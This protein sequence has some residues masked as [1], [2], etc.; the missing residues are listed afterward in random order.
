MSEGTEDLPPASR[1][2]PTQ[3][4]PRRRYAVTASLTLV[5]AVLTAGYSGDYESN[6][7]PDLRVLFVRQRDP[8]TIEILFDTEHDLS[9]MVA[10]PKP[11]WPVIRA[12]TFRR[13]GNQADS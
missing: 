11:D 6:A 3:G 2:A 1:P 13:I 8:W 5:Q 7:P 10:D 4:E 12:F 9:E